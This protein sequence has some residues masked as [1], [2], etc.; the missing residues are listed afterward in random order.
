MKPVQVA[1]S[2]VGRFDRSCGLAARVSP[3]NFLGTACHVGALI[4]GYVLGVFACSSLQASPVDFVHQVR[5]ILEKH[6]YSCH[7]PDKQKSSLRLDIKS[8][9]MKGGDAYG[10]AILPGRSA[11]SVFIQFIA[12]PDADMQMPPET[13]LSESEIK[14]LTDWVNAGAEWPDGIDTGILVDKLDH[15]SFHPI[16]KR[17]PPDLEDDDWC[18]NDVDRFILEKLTANNFRPAPEASPRDWLRRVTFDLTGLP[19]TPESLQNFVQELSV[20]ETREAVYARVVDRLLDSPRYGERW[21]QHW[22]DVVRYAD[23]HGFEVNTERPH[24]WP[25]RDYVIQALNHDLPY[26]QFIREQIAGDALGTDAATGFLITAS[27]LLPGQIGKDEPSK[28]LARQ[29]SIDEIVTNIGQTFLGLSI[30]CARCHDHKFDPISHLDYY[31]MQA[32]VSGVWYENREVETHLNVESKERIAALQTELADVERRLT[33]FVPLW[34]AGVTRSPVNARLNFDRFPAVATKRL[35]FEVLKTNK[36]EPCLDELEVF[37]QRGE[38]VALASAGTVATSSGETLV[39]GVHDLAYVNDGK[40]GN[41]SSWMSNE[42]GRGWVELEFSSEQVIE[43][44]D[45]ARDRDARYQDRLATKYRIQVADPQGNWKVVADSEDRLKYSGEQGEANVFQG[46]P[47]KAEK[48]AQRLLKSRQ[49]VAKQMAKL[50]ANQ[51]IFAGQF[52]KPDD[53]FLLTRGDPE[54]PKQKVT[55]AILSSF[56]AI[57]LPEETTEQARRIALADWI[58]S[59]ENLF[60]ARVMVNRIWQG[61][62]GTGLVETPSDFGR[63]GMPPTHPELLDWLGEQFVQSGWSIK[64]MHRLIVLSSAYRQSTEFNAQA[65]LQDAEAKLLWRYPLRRHDAETI[66]DSILA[67]SGRLNLQM[68]GPGFDLFNQRG[69]LSGFV[70]VETFDENGRRR[71]IYAHQVRRERDPVF[72][73]FDRPDGGQSLARRSESTTPLQAL[74]LFNSPFMLNECRAMADRL[75]QEAGTNVDQQ[76]Q[77]AWNL[78]FGR[79]PENEELMEARDVVHRQGLSMLCRIIMNSNEFLFMP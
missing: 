53:I 5:P 7:G 45:W 65:A 61:H 74:N 79:D 78:A 62:F 37:N 59:P 16:K 71:M 41:K 8:E 72:G 13:R 43:R 57:Q 49:N 28:R 29:D 50:H 76:I 2:A 27:V 38:N 34:Q 40:Y 68:G 46:T 75:H 10:P 66:R 54:Q 22:L 58:A 18:R 17:T 23:T 24:A 31:S 63:S 48:Q 44:V 20:S 70:P 19:A 67:C 12:D 36:L 39:T 33:T 35:R 11:E 9:A 3:V 47:P 60:T 30:G 55:P 73:A 4:C 14:I 21:A 51:L 52:R 15:W 64:Q 69:G 32:F 1:L 25:Y 77:R 56:G 42:T 6:C 26:D